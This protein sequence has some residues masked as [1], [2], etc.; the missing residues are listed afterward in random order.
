VPFGD[1]RMFVF[2]Q[3]GRIKILEGGQVRPRALPRRVRRRPA[4]T[5]A[6]RLATFAVVLAAAQA[7]WRR[8]R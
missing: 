7:S 6:V 1:S 2:E 8:R 5:T 3:N 4:N